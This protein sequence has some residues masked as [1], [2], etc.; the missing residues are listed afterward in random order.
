MLALC[1]FICVVFN[2]VTCVIR[3]EV[4]WEFVDRYCC[5]CIHIPA[6]ARVG[7]CEIVLVSSFIVLVLV[8]N[9]SCVIHLGRR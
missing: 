7:L 2:N 4:N 9:I 5:E 3:V 1:I 6:F 8:V